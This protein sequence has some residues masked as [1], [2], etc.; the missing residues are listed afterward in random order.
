MKQT[1]YLKVNVM[2]IRYFL[3]Y[4]VNILLIRY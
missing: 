4:K 2:L 1:L 3:T